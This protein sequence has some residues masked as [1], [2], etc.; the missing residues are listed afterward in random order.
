LRFT[1]SAEKAMAEKVED[2]REVQEVKVQ[3]PKRANLTAE[4]SL[5]RMEAFPERKEQIV[6]AVRKGKNRN[7]PA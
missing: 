2:A 1:L 4:E 5:Q 6:A 3:R 7:L